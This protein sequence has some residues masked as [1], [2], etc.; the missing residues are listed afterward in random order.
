MRKTSTLTCAA[1]ALACAL[2]G[3]GTS[4]APG[5]QLAPSAGSTAAAITTVTATSTTATSTTAAST[6]TG[7]LP[8]ALNTKPSVPIPKGA[9]PSKL[10][11][12]DLIKGTGAAATASSTVT[13]QYVGV[14]YKNGKQFD[15]SWNDGAG[16]PV[17]FP[18]TGVIKGWTEGI[19][20]MRI[21][22]RRE[23]II[24]PSLGYGATAQAKI[25]A[26]STLVFVIDLH[27][28]S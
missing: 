8:A 15:A 21:G 3:C 4:T 11:I 20:G 6:T 24:P 22:G 2:A 16:K 5:V 14:L 7:A 26:N 13:V 27:A 23:L 12:K 10:V 18:L 9:P 25:P 28:I 19:P 17:S 1:V